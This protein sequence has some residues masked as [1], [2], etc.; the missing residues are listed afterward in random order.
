MII[1]KAFPISLGIFWRLLIVIPVFLV[2]ATP[3]VVTFTLFLPFVGR[4]SSSVASAFFL[5][6]GI[7]AGFQA[8]KVYT[9]P[10]FNRLLMSSI[11]WGIFEYFVYLLIFM[12]L[13]L[14]VWVVGL[15]DLDDYRT[16]FDRFDPEV[17]WDFFSVSPYLSTIG[18]IT[19]ALI[20]G[21]STAFAVPK[22]A[23]AHSA[24][25]R[26]YELN[27]F[28]GFGAGFVPILA[29]TLG[30]YAVMY[31]SGAYDAIFDMIFAGF[32]YINHVA[33][34]EPEP[35]ITESL[36]FRFAIG[37]ALSF[38]LYCYWYAVV[39]VAFLD[40]YRKA[41]DKRLKV[42]KVPVK[43]EVDLSDLR[44]RRMQGDLKIRS[45]AQDD[46]DDEDDDD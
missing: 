45:T 20:L 40:R 6:V 29:V 35:E 16:L 5:L 23:A 25:Q 10:V 39:T 33:F 24:G 36:I 3:F 12:F 42:S 32:E 18:G 7:R 41:E 30:A 1:L 34:N 26:T 46:L 28:W 14:G 19:V 31:H 2:I 27:F 4:F 44:K 11:K 22:A 15:Y 43:H 17:W 9:A 37:V 8:C 21:L 13:F 38:W